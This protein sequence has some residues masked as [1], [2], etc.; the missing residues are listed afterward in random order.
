MKI[1][2]NYLQVKKT[3]IY[4]L[5]QTPSVLLNVPLKSASFHYNF[6]AFQV[7]HIKPILQQH[8]LYGTYLRVLPTMND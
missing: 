1:V 7:L 8:L 6:Q 4:I 5:G 3:I 2:D